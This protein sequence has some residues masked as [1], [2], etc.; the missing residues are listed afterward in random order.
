MVFQ[1][2]G[3]LPE[4]LCVHGQAYSLSCVYYPIKYRN[5][6]CRFLGMHAHIPLFAFGGNM[7]CFNI[8]VM[9]K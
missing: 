5:Y 6:A 1:K 2:M 9:F 8:H 4:I 3:S 7:R